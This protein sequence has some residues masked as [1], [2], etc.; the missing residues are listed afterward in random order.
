MHGLSSE[1]ETGEDL[2]RKGTASDR[3]HEEVDMQTKE[4]ALKPAQVVKYRFHTHAIAV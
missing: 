2:G 1:V 3:S 4:K